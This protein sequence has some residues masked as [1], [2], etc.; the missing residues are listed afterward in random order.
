M[1]NLSS[2]TVVSTGR[3]HAFD[4]AT[5]LSN[6]GLLKKLYTGYPRAKSPLL[7]DGEVQN[8]PWLM[9][10]VIGIHRVFGYLPQ[11]LSRMAI[12]DFDSFVGRELD[13]NCAVL[14]VWSG[15]ASSTV[16]KLCAEKRALRIVCERGSTHILHQE[17]VIKLESDRLGYRYEGV[18]P[19][20][21]DRESSD[22][23]AAD[24]IVVPSEFCAKTF[25]AHGVSRDKVHVIPYGVDLSLFRPSGQSPKQRL[26]L[27]AGQFTVRKGVAYLIDAMKSL[28]GWKLL[29]SGPVDPQSR[30]M[31][32]SQSNC[33][34]IGV[35]TRLQLAEV[36]SQCWALVLPSLEEGM[37]LVQAQAMA[38]GLPVIATEEAGAE[39]LFVDGKEGVLIQSRS[40]SAIVDAILHLEDP[41]IRMA[42]SENAVMRTRSLGG[43]SL[44]V[45]RCVGLYN[46][47]D[48]AAT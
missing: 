7:P 35:L 1:T 31:L 30:R 37:A 42:M 32:S 39:D 12:H 14:H 3:F 17:R 9:P 33:E 11:G 27:F 43:W 25:V 24:A 38:C 36:M 10:F 18:D 47:L 40:A 34:H 16:R 29:V 26:L 13:P 48:K 20:V 19:W 46:I 44:Y 4:L 8:R 45:D 2:V 23:E 5:G 41:S 15:T 6:R 22:Y 28:P 21:K